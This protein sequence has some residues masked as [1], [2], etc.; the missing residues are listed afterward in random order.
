MFEKVLTVQVIS[1]F[2]DAPNTI[3]LN[4]PKRFFCHDTARDISNN[5]DLGWGYDIIFKAYKT[6]INH[7]NKKN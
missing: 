4:E 3:K 6:K 2:Q 7:K 5:I 1:L